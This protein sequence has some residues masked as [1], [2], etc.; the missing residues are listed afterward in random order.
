LDTGLSRRVLIV[1][2]EN[3]IAL[4]LTKIFEGAGYEAKA[5]G[6]AE[7]ALDVMAI[8]EPALLVVDIMLPKM[9]GVELAIRI[10]KGYPACQVILFSG[11]GEASDWLLFAREDRP[12]F[13]V[14][15]KPV[16][17]RDLLILAA[18][19]LNRKAASVSD[20]RSSLSSC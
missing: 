18:H 15:A 19:L 16:H 5:T 2:D 14:I 3:I 17:P 6:S 7:D 10:R 13:E 12:S 1:D 11:H 8:W 9:N 4:T 20:A